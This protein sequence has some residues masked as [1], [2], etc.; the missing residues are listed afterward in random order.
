MTH[1]ALTL[2]LL[3][4]L[5][6]TFTS[7]QTEDARFEKL[8]SDFLTGYFQANPTT[9]TQIGNHDNDSVLDDVSMTALELETKRV[10]LFREKL[11]DFDLK[12]L[13]SRNGTDARILTETL[14]EMIF[15]FDELKEYQWNPL[16]YTGTLG[17]AIASLIYQDFAPLDVR[18]QNAAA[19]AR[20]V[21]R[22]LADAKSMLQDAPAMHV[23][24]AVQQNKGNVALYGDELVKSA[25]AASPEVQAAVKSASTEAVKALQAFGVWLEKDLLPRAKRDTR[26][27]RELYEKK[28][29][30]LLKSQYTPAQILARAEAEEKRVLGEMYTISSQLY[31]QYYGGQAGG[32]DSLEVIRKV[33]AKVVLEHTDKDH[34]MDTIRSIIPDL[35]QF[36]LS[37]QLLTQDLTQIVVIRETPEYER[38]VAV[39]SLESPG[40]LEKKL[41]SFYNVMP[42]PSDWSAEQVESFLRE[43]NNWSL[44]ELS[45]HEGVPGHF[46]QGYYANR[47]PSVLRSIFASG[48]MVEGWAVYAERMMVDEGYMNNDPRMKLINLKW[49]LRTVL[50][51]I[52]DQRIHA[53]G[54]TEQEVMNLLTKEGFQE[55]R[56]AAGKWKRANLTSAQLSTY[57]VGFLEI[58]DLRDAYREMKGSAYSLKEFNEQFLSYGS[59][60][61]KYIR[62]EM[63]S[64]G[65]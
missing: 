32:T 17:N 62:E 44:R 22:F 61:V 12:R 52:I 2:M 35:E 11:A 13:S 65:K 49:Y 57:F 36:V 53:Y 19:R 64:R 39:A 51:A 26:L 42:I 25:A 47:Y 29:T 21:P 45:I 20:Q 56:E 23:A 50:N 55:E 46:V 8:S 48:S 63:I 18:L 16:V 7:S 24:T 58:W 31:G 4:A 43:Y 1:R 60:P 38:G 10:K 9:A 59:P 30:H 27:G 37:H 14:D 5:A 34:V 6:S 41:K 54:W 3:L 15:G 40:P 28:L 33:L